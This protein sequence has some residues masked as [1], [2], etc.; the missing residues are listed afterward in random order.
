[1]LQAQDLAS[2]VKVSS[3]MTAGAT[4]ASFNGTSIDGKDN[5]V[6][7]IQVLLGTVTANDASNFMT[8]T[9]EDSDD[10][11]TWAAVSNGPSKSTVGKVEGD[12]LALPYKGVKRYYRLVGTET[13]TFSAVLSAS[14][15][16]LPNHLP[17][18]S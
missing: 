15:I 7:G 10:G 14:A 13:G 4:T 5:S 1:M 3:A 9:L 2:N 6:K 12:R 17:I 18:A 16:E 8:F 11:S